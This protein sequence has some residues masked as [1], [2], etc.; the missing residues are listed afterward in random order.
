MLP[1]S[2]LLV[3]A[4]GA[5]ALLLSLGAGAQ[6]ADTATTAATA[7]SA[8]PANE[9]SDANVPPATA[10]RQAAEIARGEPARWSHE[11]MSMAARLKNRR[12]EIAAALQESQGVCRSRPREERAACLKQARDTYRQ[13]MAG[14]RGELTAGQ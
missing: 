11:D 14:V 4:V 3:R 13:D 1:M 5:C 10:R 6:T 12:K 2:N 9:S 8:A 7:P